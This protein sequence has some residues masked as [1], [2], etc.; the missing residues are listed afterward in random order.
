MSVTPQLPYSE[1]DLFAVPLRK[2][3]YAVGL[4]ARTRPQGEV[5]FGYFFGPRREAL[6]GAQDLQ[7]LTPTDAVLV[8]QFGDLRLIRGDWPM[9]GRLRSWKREHWPMPAFVR[10]DDVSNEARL[11]RYSEDDPNHE[12]ANLPCTAEQ[13][14]RLPRDAMMGAGAVEIRLTKRLHRVR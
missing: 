11:I 1:G 5:V 2:G 9:L 13:A 14:E 12:I 7:T 3:G 4:I 10:V 8:G 6:P